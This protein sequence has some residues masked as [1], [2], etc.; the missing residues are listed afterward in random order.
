MRLAST[1]A[2][3]AILTTVACQQINDIVRVGDTCRRPGLHSRFDLFSRK[4]AN[5]MGQAEA[6]H[7]LPAYSRSDKFR[8]A[9]RHR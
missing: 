7:S 3:L 5:D 4:V 8:D 6:L 1:V 2:L 9:W